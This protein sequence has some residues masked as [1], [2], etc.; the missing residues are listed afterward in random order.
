MCVVVAQECFPIIASLALPCMAC[1]AAIGLFDKFGRQAIK[2]GR[3]RFILPNGDEL[4]YGPG[5]CMRW[6]HAG[7]CMQWVHAVGAACL[8][9]AIG[10]HGP[11]LQV[12]QP[13]RPS[14]CPGT[15]LQELAQL[16]VCRVGCVVACRGDHRR[17]CAQGGGVAGAAPSGCDRAHLPCRLL[18]VDIQL[19][20]AAPGCTQL[21]A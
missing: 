1:C 4:I 15:L 10:P 3:L 20:P 13:R 7:G 5:G 18:Q 16:I 12:R 14:M 6:V 8:P 17:A 19:H 11:H 21:P 9:C 2:T